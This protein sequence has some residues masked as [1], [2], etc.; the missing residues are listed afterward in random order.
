MALSPRTR[1]RLEVAMARRQE[2]MEIADAIDAATVASGSSAEPVADVA[3]EDATDE[4]TAAALANANKATINALLAALRSA[5]LM[6][7]A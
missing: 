1:R 3:V 5:G 7:T 6:K 2:A 4:Q